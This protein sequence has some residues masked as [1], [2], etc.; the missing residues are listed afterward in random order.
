MTTPTNYVSTAKADGGRT[1]ISEPILSEKVLPENTLTDSF[2]RSANGRKASKERV[3]YSIH[4]FAV[5]GKTIV[6]V[7]FPFLASQQKFRRQTK[8]K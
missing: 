4:T 3:I 6:P 5:N 1:S 8:T 7:M 2:E